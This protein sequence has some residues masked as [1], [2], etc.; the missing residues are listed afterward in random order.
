M[1]KKRDREREASENRRWLD[2]E[3]RRRCEAL[4]AA[5]AQR[6]PVDGLYSIPLPRLVDDLDEIER[7]RVRRPQPA[8]KVPA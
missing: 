1:S 3:R 5:E 4:A 7:L 8:K 2:E 6:R